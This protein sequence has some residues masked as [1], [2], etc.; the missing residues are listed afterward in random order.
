MKKK[1]EVP[2]LIIIKNYIDEDNMD[3]RGKKIL[4]NIMSYDRGG[5]YTF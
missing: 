4:D 5:S 1:N 3:K 2:N